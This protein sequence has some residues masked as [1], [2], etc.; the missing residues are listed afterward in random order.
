M[1]D[2]AAETIVQM[3]MVTQ[4]TGQIYDAQVE[5]LK[6]M[7][8]L[9]FGHPVTMTIAP[10]ELEGHIA[11]QIQGVVIFYKQ[12][13]PDQTKENLARQAV[14]QVLGK[15]W[16]VKVSYNDYHEPS[17]PAS[18]P[19][20]RGRKTGVRRVSGKRTAAPKRKNRS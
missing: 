5:T 13:D 11:E 15:G 19:L 17:S 7:A 3:R 2:Q 18:K 10:A 16:S 6:K 9:L 4:M 20:K 14:Q 8:V 12:S 1:S